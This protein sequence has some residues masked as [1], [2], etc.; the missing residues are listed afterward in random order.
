MDALEIRPQRG[1]RAREAG[2]SM[3]AGERES[4]LTE[5]AAKG[6]AA[7]TVERYRRSLEQLSQA[8]PEDGRI[9]R[10]TLEQ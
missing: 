5:L 3:T 2:V 10:G 1:G 4:F 9:R 6:R 7:D 8:L